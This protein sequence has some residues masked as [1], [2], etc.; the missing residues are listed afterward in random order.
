MKCPLKTKPNFPP[1][2]TELF[3]TS[4]ILWTGYTATKNVKYED[5]VATWNNS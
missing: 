4:N 5:Y 3:G 1:L 2:L